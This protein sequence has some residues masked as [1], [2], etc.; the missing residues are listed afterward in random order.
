M[1][2]WGGVDAAIQPIDTGSRYDPLTDSW[3][4]TGSVGAPRKRAAH[5]AVWTGTEMIVWGIFPDGARYDPVADSWVPTNDSNPSEKRIDHVAVWTGAEMIV[6]AGDFPIGS[7]DPEGT[8]DRY[9]PATDSWQPMNV[10]GA[11]VKRE[12]GGTAVWTGTEMLVFGGQTATALY[13]VGGKYN[14][15][16][17]SWTSM[18]SSGAP[19]ARAY[20]ATVWTGTEMLVGGGSHS[21]DAATGFETSTGGRYDPLADSWT[22]TSTVG[23]P[24][25]RAHPAGVWTG[26]E[27]IVWGGYGDFAT[28]NSGGRYDLATD[29]WTPTT[30]IGAPSSSVC[31]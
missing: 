12:H 2:V 18:S 20:S 9:D 8:G 27:L 3:T 23:V 6:W 19:E 21:W 7:L 25:A 28:L 16:T 4:P 30:M 29:S 14:P 1:I 22:P 17:D 24:Q 13:G 26:S 11:P 31:W 10:A 15:T 5:S